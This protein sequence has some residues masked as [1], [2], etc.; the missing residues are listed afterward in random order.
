VTKQSEFL[1]KNQSG[2]EKNEQNKNRRY[3][4]K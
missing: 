1:V 3:N 2:E 4:G